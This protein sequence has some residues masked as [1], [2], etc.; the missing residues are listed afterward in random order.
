[1]TY[2]AFRSKDHQEILSVLAHARIDTDTGSPPMSIEIT[3]LIEIGAFD[4]ATAFVT[5]SL[6][7]AVSLYLTGHGF[8]YKE[9]FTVSEFETSQSARN[10]ELI[11]LLTGEKVEIDLDHPDLEWVKKCYKETKK[12]AR[13]ELSA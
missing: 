8:D 13:R 4:R 10:F 6:E 1:M 2:F 7:L 3:P 9:E 5:T 12:K 11:D